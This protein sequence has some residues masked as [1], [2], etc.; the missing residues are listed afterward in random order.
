MSLTLTELAAEGAMRHTA[1]GATL[2][3]GITRPDLWAR[4]DAEGARRDASS[5]LEIATTRLKCSDGTARALVREYLRFVYLTQVSD[6]VVAPSR[7]VDELWH[8]HLLHSS[9]YFDRFCPQVLGK[10]L[11][12][13]PGR[14][15]PQDDPAHDHAKRLYRAVFG[16]AA[17]WRFWPNRAQETRGRVAARLATLALLAFFLTFTL[18]FAVKFLSESLKYAANLSFFV[19]FVLFVCVFVIQ[20]TVP[21]QTG[22]APSDSDGGCGGCG[23]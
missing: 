19:T 17:P 20:F 16:E 22:D 14:P 9:D 4:L 12:H 18:G 21:A 5:L 3:L 23:G 2:S 1:D 10:T 6:Q 15:G 11:H 7:I 8:E 13:M